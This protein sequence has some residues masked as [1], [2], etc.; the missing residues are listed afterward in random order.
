[1]SKMASLA[2]LKVKIFAD[3]ADLK[4]IV[5]LSKDPMV[6]GFTTNPSLM[7]KDGVSDYEQFARNLLEAV[8]NH[9]I[10]FEVFADDFKEM[11]AQARTIAS[12]GSNVYVKIPVTNT[13]KQS[14]APLISKLS[15]EGI[16]L[17]VTAILTLDQVKEVA[18]ALHVNTPAVVSVFAGRIADTGVDPMPLM[19][20]SAKILKSKP[21]AELLWASSR[22]LLNIFQADATGSQIITVTYDMLKKLSLIGKDLEAYSLE[23]VEMFYRDATAA[24]FTINT[25]SGAMA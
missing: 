5:A 8:P 24:G 18:N 21:K 25:R 14:A 3:G 7:R 2:S 15:A 23:T 10:S 4:S 20:E 6:S 11:E 1:M 13:K 16:A 22:E 9:P 17:N 12:W 19:A